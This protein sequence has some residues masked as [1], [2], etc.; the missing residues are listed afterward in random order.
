LAVP[1]CTRAAIH[2]IGRVVSLRSRAALA[3]LLAVGL[4]KQI[5]FS[6]PVEEIA[7]E[8]EVAMLKCLAQ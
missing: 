3:R 6:A 1:I 2:L 4:G 5:R 8:L 7:A